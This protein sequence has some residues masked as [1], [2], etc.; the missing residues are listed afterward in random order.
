MWAETKK[1]ESEGLGVTAPER[2]EYG[3]NRV[4]NIERMKI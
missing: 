4:Y 3:T 2:V 1:G